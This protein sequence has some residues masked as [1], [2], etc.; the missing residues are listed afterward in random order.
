MNNSP[1]LTYWRR[2]QEKVD[3][4]KTR[5]RVLVLLMAF[6]VIYM[7]W[8]F[9][10]FNPLAEAKSSIDKEVTA[11]EQ[12]IGAMQ[13][14]E[15]AILSAVNADPDR[16]VKQR[17]V[18]LEQQ[19]NQLN[20]TLE[21]LSLGLVPVE[22]LTSILRDVLQSTG[23]LQLQSLRTLPVEAVALSSPASA[24]DIADGED[25]IATTGVYRHRV[26]LTVKG[27]FR[28]LIDYLRALE[29]MHWRFYWDELLFEEDHYPDALIQLHVYTLSTDEGLFGV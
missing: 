21:E 13:T 5:E 20:T 16:D 12:K 3:A 17:I 1:L 9:L 28:E 23:G 24:D 10:I 7:V 14:E 11:V 19:L 27:D 18:L 8:D 22:K 26:T 15:K 4:L 25:E 29:A 2:Y 6:A